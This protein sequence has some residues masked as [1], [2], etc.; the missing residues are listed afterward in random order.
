MKIRHGS[1]AKQATYL[2]FMLQDLTL[3]PRD[4]KQPGPAHFYPQN[5][6]LRVYDNIFNS[7]FK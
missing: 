6:C 4:P 7:L 5:Y 1:R 3:C 2:R